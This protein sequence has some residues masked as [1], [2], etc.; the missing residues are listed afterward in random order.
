M[1]TY[2][3][4]ELLINHNAADLIPLRNEFFLSELLCR[5]ALRNLL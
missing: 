1:V 3:C 5:N 4:R 2:V